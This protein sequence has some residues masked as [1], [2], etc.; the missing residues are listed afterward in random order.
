MQN[1]QWSRGWEGSCKGLNGNAN[2]HEWGMRANR[3][4]CRVLLMLFVFSSSF[5]AF[6]V[7]QAKSYTCSHS[8]A[9]NQINCFVCLGQRREAS[10][11]K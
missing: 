4:W 7:E 10:G 8:F 2:K 3:E 11:L 6:L 5:L 9:F 1:M